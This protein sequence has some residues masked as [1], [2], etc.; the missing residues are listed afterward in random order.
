MNANVLY[1]LA[2]YDQLSTPGVEE[3]ISFINTATQQRFHVT[4]PE[5]VSD[6]YPDN[7]AYHYCISRAYYEGP[8]PALQPAVEI[9]ADEIEQTVQISQDGT[10]FWDKGDTH[11]NTA[12]AVLTLLNAGRIVPLIEIAVDYLLSEQDSTYGNWDEGIFFV[13]RPE[14]GQVICFVSPALTT[15]VVLEALCRHKLADHH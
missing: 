6:Y 12:F 3:A 15:A 1:V 9:L 11:L 7:F 10:A 14:G 2:R 5:E 8:V 4:R 13:G